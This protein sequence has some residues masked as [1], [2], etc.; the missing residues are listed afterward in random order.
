MFP[1]A[2]MLLVIPLPFLVFVSA[3]I[4]ADFAGMDRNGD[5]ACDPA[6]DMGVAAAT[7]DSVESVD[8]YFDG[9]R[10]M[11]SWACTF[12]VQD[13]DMISNPS[14]VMNLP[15]DW[16]FG[17]YW[18]QEPSSEIQSTY[19]NY[20][21]WQAHALINPGSGGAIALPAII[22]TFNYTVS[23]DGCIG[24]VIDG[25]QTAI[26]S[27]GYQT[28]YYDTPDKHCPAFHCPSTATEELSW[29]NVKMLFR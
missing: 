7:A 12:C 3:A 10:R 20:R 21:C 18:E 4:P 25:T 5:L 24:F 1:R 15:S 16:V 26:L 27:S 29:G 14:F 22:G 2:C 8:F 13:K 28:I 17:Y 19:P 23:Q 9:Y 6:I 11:I